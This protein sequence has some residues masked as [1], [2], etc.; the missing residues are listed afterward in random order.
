MSNILLQFTDH[1]IEYQPSTNK[2]L[3]VLYHIK[4]SYRT[5]NSTTA[6]YASRAN[7]ESY[8]VIKRYS[9][10]LELHKK[11]MK[12]L[13]KRSSSSSNSPRKEK[14][15]SSPSATFQE[16]G[17]KFPGKLLFGNFK[18]ENIAKR[19]E[20]LQKYF[21]SITSNPMI[22]QDPLCSQIIY[23]FFRRNLQR[24]SPNVVFGEYY[25]KI[26][27]KVKKMATPFGPI[28]EHEMNAV[29]TVTSQV[30]KGYSDS[31]FQNIDQIKG[32][33]H[34]LGNSLDS[35]PSK[36]DEDDLD[37]LY[38]IVNSSP[39]DTFDDEE[40]GKTSNKNRKRV[41][42][43]PKSMWFNM[44]IE[45]SITCSSSTES[46]NGSSPRKTLFST[47]ESI[48]SMDWNSAIADLCQVMTN[49]NKAI[50]YPRMM[51]YKEC[52]E[53]YEKQRQERELALIL[54]FNKMQKL[55]SQKNQ[56]LPEQSKACKNCL[57]ALAQNCVDMTLT[58][59][60]ISES[61]ALLK[62]YFSEL[63]NKNPATQCK[64]FTD[65]L[66]SLKEI[67]QILLEQVKKGQQKIMTLRQILKTLFVVFDDFSTRKLS[68]F[69]QSQNS[70][71]SNA[72]TTSGTASADHDADDPAAVSSEDSNSSYNVLCREY[73]ETYL[74]PF[75]ALGY[76]S[77]LSFMVPDALK[78]F[79]I[80][81]CSLREKRIR[82]I[83][84]H[85]Q[86]SDSD[87]NS[88]MDSQMKQAMEKLFA[89]KIPQ[90]DETRDAI[91][92][93]F[94]SELQS[95]GNSEIMDPEV[96]LFCIPEPLHRTC[97]LFSMRFLSWVN[98][99]PEVE[100]FQFCKLMHLQY[101]R[102]TQQEAEQWN[103]M[104]NMCRKTLDILEQATTCF[105]E[106]SQEHNIT[107]D[108]KISITYETKSRLDLISKQFSGYA[109]RLHY[110]NSE[111][112][113][114]RLL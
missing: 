73:I 103:H 39:K 44:P 20:E 51:M 78:Y 96:L 110:Y 16:E 64:E 81:N 10:L 48:L 14:H 58:F 72:S 67:L 83:L 60:E 21:D 2:P 95:L 42:P 43:E 8:T 28:S 9:E 30:S 12:Q 4:C 104:V 38:L 109:E 23:A 97:T 71:T 13:G 91:A 25:E 107:T 113:R 87:S 93:A 5:N 46:L 62:K 7:Q 1:S 76:V 50:Q 41:T 75:A 6:F 79:I 36:S 18:E 89:E 55:F 101:S 22:T 15:G 59:E 65:N 47:V 40:K 99:L 106:H 17:I 82:R 29:M 56:K 108:L 19:K 80:Y 45:N 37:D 11:I 69:S 114:F 33:E 85:N 32:L 90:T 74:L 77:E 31:V 102:T 35:I 92:R 84:A 52:C 27:E 94:Q 61:F 70:Q 105:V 68:A 26:V 111:S 53:I 112:K 49:Y 98:Q 54:I 24:V 86:K 63:A 66:E 34:L 57:S 88:L 3:Y 100:G